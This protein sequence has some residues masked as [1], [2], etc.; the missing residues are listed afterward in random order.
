MSNFVLV[1]DEV[2]NKLNAKIL[3]AIKALSP[4]SFVSAVELSD[5]VKID[6]KELVDRL[7]SLKKSAKFYLTSF[8]Q[9]STGSRGDCERVFISEHFLKDQI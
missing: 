3:K 1:G 6:K 2:L 5:K 7:M 8:W 4:T 9:V